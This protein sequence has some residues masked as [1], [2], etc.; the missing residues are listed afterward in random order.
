MTLR[1]F[2]YSL[3]LFL[4]S[5]TFAQ[6]STQKLLA[7]QLVIAEASTTLLEQLKDP[8]F[9]ADKAK[10]R[11]FID[12]HIF[13]KVDTVRMSAL[14]LGKHWRKAEK[15]EKKRFIH[16]FKQLLV[17]TYAATFTEQFHNWSIQYAP[18]KI[19]A[20]DKKALVKTKI[21]QAGKPNTQIDYSMVLRNNQWKI[22]DMKVEGISLVISNRTTFNQMIK[23]SGS[24]AEV[25]AQ[26]ERKNTN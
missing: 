1:P 16:A 12:S 18:L 2:Y 5:C 7:P 17:N 13:S 10:V 22:Y 6:A 3:I 26:L 25:I 14:V 24:L 11:Q 4:F 9:S 19:K 8:Q 21:Q 23:K 15:N 20:S